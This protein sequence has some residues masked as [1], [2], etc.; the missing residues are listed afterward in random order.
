M[1]H[2]TLRWGII[3][4]ANIA[5][6]VAE[7]IHKAPN[8]TLVA[9]ASRDLS[10]AE[11]FAKQNNI[12]KAYG[13]YEELL[14]DKNVDAVYIPLPTVIR[15]EWAIKAAKAGKHILVDKPVSVS[16]DELREIGKACKENNV[17]YMVCYFLYH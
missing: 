14:Q 12:P 13:S 8:A 11:N 1:T 10:K 17:H 3:S 6:K 2:S 7:A 16:A 9:V 4:T 5:N 15:A